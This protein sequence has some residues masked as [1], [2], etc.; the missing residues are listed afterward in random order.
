MVCC[1]SIGLCFCI[2]LCMAAVFCF[3]G[4]LDVILA[5]DLQ[6]EVFY[7]WSHTF[8]ENAK[9]TYRCHIDF[10]ARFCL[11]MTIPTVPATTFNIGLYVAF[12]ATSFKPAS[13]KQYVS[14]IGLI[15]KEFG[16]ANPL[17]DN[18]LID[19]LFKGI[20]RMKGDSHVQKLTITVDT[21]LCLFK[22]INFKSSLHSS[23]WAIC[24]TSFFGMFRKSNLLST[25]AN[26][27]SPDQ[28]LTK[29]DFTFCSWGVLIHVK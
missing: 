15:H 28:Q 29:F 18:Y 8:S 11:F 26:S 23:F 17:T 13:V 5:K 21:L 27:F 7:Y 24:L 1:Y 25:S 19:S 4:T 12:I 20:K 2:C 10:H 9:R 6:N 22:T 16:L 3:L 14:A